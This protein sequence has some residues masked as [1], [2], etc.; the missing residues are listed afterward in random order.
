[1]ANSNESSTYVTRSGRTSH[2]IVTNLFGT[3]TRSRNNNMNVIPDD[4]RNEARR[5]QADLERQEAEIRRLTQQLNEQTNNGNK[6]QEEL[7]Q[8][9]EQ[10]RQVQESV[11]PQ[12]NNIQI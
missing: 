8:S 7:Q 10:L 5:H 11:Q 3:S 4:P 1:M 2:K 6:L 9:R 12:Q